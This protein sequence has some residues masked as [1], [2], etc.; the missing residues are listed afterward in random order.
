MKSVIDWVV[1]QRYRPILLAMAFSALVPVVAT[2]LLGLVTVRRGAAQAAMSAAAGV[3][4]MALIEVITSGNVGL[5]T[6]VAAGAMTAGIA[7]GAL[8]T[9]ARGLSLSFQATLLFCVVVAVG[10]TLFGPTPHQIFAAATDWLVNSLQKNG[11]T[12]A[13]LQAARSLDSLLL[14]IGIAAAF[15]A[16][17][18]GLLLTYWWVSLLRT[19]LAF[20]RE[21]RLLKMGHVLGVPALVVVSIGLVLNTPVIQN[22]RL[23]A[24]FAFLFQGLAVMHAWAHARKWHPALVGLVYVLF[25]PPLSLAAI[26]GFSILGLL[27]NVFEL[28]SPLRTQA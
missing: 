28:R 8:V 3:A 25:V 11:A 6:A 1:A 13:Q 20:G 14:G 7:L 9:W 4:A 5:L 21:F 12:E 27:D 10:F 17:V 2:A 26:L 16:L 19:D 15:T 18:T 22:L 24:L 23:L